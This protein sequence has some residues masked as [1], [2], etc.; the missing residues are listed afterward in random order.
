MALEAREI[1]LKSTRTLESQ[2]ALLGL[3]LIWIIISYDYWV[4]GWLVG[5]WL[6][7]RTLLTLHHLF[8]KWHQFFQCLLNI[9]YFQFDLIQLMLTVPNKFTYLLQWLYFTTNKCSACKDSCFCC[10]FE[11]FHMLTFLLFFEAFLWSFAVIKRERLLPDSYFNHALKTSYEN[12]FRTV[13][14]SIPKSNWK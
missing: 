4:W 2:R 1:N 3:H 9:Y 7:T 6:S 8:D 14:L 12:L 10:V 11:S 5:C 13:D